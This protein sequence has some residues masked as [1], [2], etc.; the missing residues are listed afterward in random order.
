[1][2]T[3]APP[4]IIGASLMVTLHT[5]AVCRVRIFAGDGK[6]NGKQT[7]TRPFPSG[8]AVIVLV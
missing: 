8:A 5:S 7:L 2:I 3:M 4:Y 6:K 1:M